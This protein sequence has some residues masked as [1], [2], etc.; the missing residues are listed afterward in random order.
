[1]RLTVRAA[2][3]LTP[4]QIRESP[5]F[6]KW[7]SSLNDDRHQ[8]VVVND[9]D[10]RGGEI[11]TLHLTVDGKGWPERLTLC[12]ETVNV[13]VILSDG[14]RKRIAFVSRYCAG[15]GHRVLSNPEGTVR[16]GETRKEAAVRIVREALGLPEGLRMQVGKLISRPC[17][18][19]PGMTN[20][21]VH[22]MR[23]TI[24][25]S[26]ARLWELVRQLAGTETGDD[27]EAGK[28]VVRVAH[29]VGAL[30][31]FLDAETAEE[32]PPVDGRTLQALTYDMI[33]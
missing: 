13:L 17:L 14:A 18:P 2:T 9:I 23:V 3:H 20:E 6:K 26:S 27:E 30:E 32:N 24:Q 16:E 25:T 15:V 31:L 12:A 19:A 33:R 4:Q 22:F 21:K 28:L 8:R 29:Y 5:L 1:M 10:V 7:T 11:H